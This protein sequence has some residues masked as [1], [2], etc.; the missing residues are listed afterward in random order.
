MQQCLQRSLSRAQSINEGHKHARIDQQVQALH[1]H[2]FLNSGRR[3]IRGCDR[4]GV[5]VMTSMTFVH[6]LIDV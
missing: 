6:E 4:P 2:V 3:G 5:A 1:T